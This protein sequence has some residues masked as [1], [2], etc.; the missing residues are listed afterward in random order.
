MRTS[1]VVAG[2][3]IVGLSGC[4]GAD[5]PVTAKQHYAKVLEHAEDVAGTSVELV[6]VS[7]QELW[8]ELVD[9]EED[10]QIRNYE[11]QTM[12]DGRA[13]QWY[14]RFCS[15]DYDLVI[16]TLDAGR[17]IVQDVLH[18]GVCA[19]ADR[20][21]AIAEWEMDSDEAAEVLMASDDWLELE[22]DQLVTWS[23]K[24]AEDGC[25]KW[26]VTAHEMVDESEIGRHVGVV[27]SC[28]GEVELI[29]FIEGL[30]WSWS[31][32]WSLVSSGY[33]HTAV[34]GVYST[35]GQPTGTQVS[36]EL[37]HANGTVE[38]EVEYDSG[39]GTIEFTLTGPDGEVVAQGTEDGSDVLEEMEAGVYTLSFVGEGFEPRS[40]DY[41]FAVEGCT[42]N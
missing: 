40:V 8:S 30:G 24:Q 25:A 29:E 34:D 10:I 11:D 4:V 15:A 18:G 22:P 31:C 3:L 17:G 12:G 35:A 16:I 1:V 41:S 14:Y 37:H 26:K 5:E 2:L 39:T 36:K 42:T 21:D 9:E 33:S 20:P 19:D 13:I 23:L 6:Q 7:S 28:T 32:S 38:Y 27:D